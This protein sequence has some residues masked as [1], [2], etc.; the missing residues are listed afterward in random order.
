M[1]SQS[2]EVLN[3]YE[4]LLEA[5]KRKTKE[6]RKICI[7]KMYGDKIMKGLRRKQKEVFDITYILGGVTYRTYIKAKDS[8]DAVKIL[9]KKL[10]TNLICI[11]EIKK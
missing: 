10:F 4:A 11:V 6:Q 7:K 8:A 5:S 3:P 1:W 2:L 9:T